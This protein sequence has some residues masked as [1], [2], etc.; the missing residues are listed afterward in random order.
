M[1]KLDHQ[2]FRA[3]VLN[4]IDRSL[5]RNPCAVTLTLKRG[6]M[7]NG[8]YVK[9]DA[10]RASE[11]IKHFRNRLNRSLLG[12]AATRNG[13]GLACFAVY[14]GTTV[15]LPHCHLCLD[16]PDDIAIERYVAEI[17]KAW[18]AT[19]FGNHHVDIRPC[20]DFDGWLEYMTKRQTK[21]DFASSIDWNNTLPGA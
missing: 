4:F 17:E 10:I 8:A 13:R 18:H 5:W 12:R 14:E 20:Y 1:N 2:H 11:N 7:N 16:R 21:S 6:L 9:I 3:A 15:V 19:D